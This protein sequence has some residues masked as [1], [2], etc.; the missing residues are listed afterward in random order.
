[1]VV[2]LGSHGKDFT[3]GLFV[4]TGGTRHVLV[5]EGG[6]GEGEDGSGGGGDGG[7]RGGW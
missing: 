6:G 4:S 2:S 5:R 7:G 3:G 1:M